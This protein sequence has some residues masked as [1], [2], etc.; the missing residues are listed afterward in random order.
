[1]NGFQKWWNS[2]QK[3]EEP[4]KQQIQIQ[5]QATDLLVYVTNTIINE[6]NQAAAKKALSDGRF[7]VTYEDMMFILKE[8]G[9]LG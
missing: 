4:K 6:I 5:P 1:M 7:I 2:V 9:Y 3:K 8:K